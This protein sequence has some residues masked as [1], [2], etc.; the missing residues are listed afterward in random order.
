MLVPLAMND[1][2]LELETCRAID[3]KRNVAN[4]TNGSIEANQVWKS[5]LV[6][7]TIVPALE[8]E[9]GSG[10]LI[11]DC[12]GSDERQVVLTA[13]QLGHL[14]VELQL[15]LVVIRSPH[16]GFEPR[17]FVGIETAHSRRTRPE[18]IE[19]GVRQQNGDNQQQYPDDYSS[20]L[21]NRP[22]VG[23]RRR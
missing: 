8:H 21:P 18:E 17:D 23:S 7:L 4:F 20:S 9:S 1:P 14:I 16:R 5:P 10:S 3:V 13:E 15:L 19:R 12:V 6:L 11:R 22:G 2:P